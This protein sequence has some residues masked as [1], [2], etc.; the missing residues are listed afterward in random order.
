M[1]AI[2]L[3]NT[4]MASTPGSLDWATGG[5]AKAD[6]ST[7]SS[8]SVW[9]REGQTESSLETVETHNTL[10]TEQD[11]Q[12]GPYGC[13]PSLFKLALDMSLRASGIIS[14]LS[15]LHSCCQVLSWHDWPQ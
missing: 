4:G 8:A 10:P 1:E 3:A 11:L 7:V 2:L 13:S 6:L 15:M 12:M 5:L 9:S 14:P